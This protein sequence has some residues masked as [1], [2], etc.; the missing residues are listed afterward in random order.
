MQR[1]LDTIE[2]NLKEYSD[3]RISSKMEMDRPEQPEIVRAKSFWLQVDVEQA[4][5]ELFEYLI[6]LKHAIKTCTASDREY[7]QGMNMI[8]LLDSGLVAPPAAPVTAPATTPTMG[9]ES[10]VEVVIGSEILA[11]SPPDID[12]PQTPLPPQQTEHVSSPS[13]PCYDGSNI[14]LSPPY[15]NREDVMAPLVPIQLPYQPHTCSQA[16]VSRLPPSAHHF[17]GLNPLTIP[18]LCSFQRQCAAPTN[19]AP[20][21][22]TECDETEPDSNGE[23][24]DPSLGAGMDSPVGELDVVYKAPCG[25]SLR[26]PEEVLCFLVATESYGILQVDDFTFDPTVQLKCPWPPQWRRPGPCERDLSRGSEPTPVQLC[27]GEEG[28]RPEEFRYRKERWP[29]GCFL[30]SGPLFITCCDCSDGCGDTES[31]ACAGLSPRGKHYSHQRLTEPVSKGLY[32]CGPWCGCDRSRCQNRVVQRGLRVRLQVFHAGSKGWGVRCRDDLDMGTFVCTY[33]GVV[34]RA[35][36]D[37]DEPLPPKRQRAEL[38]SDDEVEVVDEW[39]VP[40][41]EGQADAEPLEPSPPG[42]PS[43]GLHVPV[44]QRPGGDVS[45]QIQAVVV[46]SFLPTQSPTGTADEEG[47]ESENVVQKPRLN[48]GPN[49]KEV[50][51]NVSVSRSP[52]KLGLK[53]N[54]TEHLYYLDATKEGNVGRFINHSCNPNLFVQNVFTDS[55]DPNFPIVAFFTSKVIKAGTELTWNYSHSPGSDPEQEVPCQCG[56]EE[57][58]GLL[59]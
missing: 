4:F 49:L 12:G 41:V 36:L 44:I 22:E 57:C 31:C 14:P 3:D 26:T 30:S 42:S 13:P 5:E 46:G 47:K 45:P 34:L 53:Q 39:L 21:A 7:V 6:H 8:T 1:F 15:P 19:L 18:L 11:V 2:E 50:D 54:S 48:S 17:Q 10:F 16:C 38:P 28:L 32:E 35:G 55:H 29:H 9:N 25:R 37:S 51:V 24:S 27:L 33:A 40:A 52:Q 58:Q 23:G 20:A 43:D 59:V 56:G